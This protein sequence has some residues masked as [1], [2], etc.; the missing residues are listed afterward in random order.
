M[1]VLHVRKCDAGLTIPIIRI[2][3]GSDGFM[4]SLALS[5]GRASVTGPFPSAFQAEKAGIATAEEGGIE[6][7]TVVCDWL[8]FGG[9]DPDMPRTP[10]GR[11]N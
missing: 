9:D 2:S 5:P 4:L 7:L 3:R 11:L 6:R 8:A 1:K 10:R